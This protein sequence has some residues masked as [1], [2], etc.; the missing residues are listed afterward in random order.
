MEFEKLYLQAKRVLNPRDISPLI[1]AGSVASAILTDKGNVYFGVCID[2][3]CGLGMCAER[4]AVAN[5]VTNGEC[6]ITKL[7]CV[8]A[9]NEILTPCGACR[10]YLMQLHENNAEIK[11]LK[12]I[13]NLSTVTLKELLP[14]WWG[15]NIEGAKSVL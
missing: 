12:N 14:D 7:V 10:E 4:N 3:A 15:N 6:E 13:D 9:S 1:S 11:I 2:T 8:S 5:M